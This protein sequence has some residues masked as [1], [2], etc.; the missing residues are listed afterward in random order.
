METNFPKEIMNIYVRM[1]KNLMDCSLA[2]HKS[3]IAFP[4][5]P[6]LA[7]ELVKQVDFFEER[8][9]EDYVKMKALFIKYTKEIDVATIIEL[10]VLLKFL[11]AS[12]DI[13]TDTADYIFT[14]ATLEG[15]V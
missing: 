3:I 4:S 11:E 12:A 14:L 6:Y 7:K 2:L 13:C 15:F 5:D 9:D 8:V 10:R 1:S